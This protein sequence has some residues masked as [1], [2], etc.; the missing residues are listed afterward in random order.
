MLKFSLLSLFF[1]IMD[2]KLSLR[3]VQAEKKSNFNFKK[4]S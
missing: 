4:G 1:N 3:K 2:R